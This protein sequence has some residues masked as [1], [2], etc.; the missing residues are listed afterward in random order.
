MKLLIIALMMTVTSA[1]ALA[2]SKCRI[3]TSISKSVA[4]DKGYNPINVMD[5]QEGD[6]LEYARILTSEGYSVLDSAR[7]KVTFEQVIERK[8]SSGSEIVYAKQHTK[9]VKG[10]YLSY[11]HD[12]QIEEALAIVRANNLP[13]CKKI[14]K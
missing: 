12:Y 4:L 1:N 2:K 6:Y 7:E 9:R 3:L 14:S 8:L 5:V 10:G 13:S 11:V